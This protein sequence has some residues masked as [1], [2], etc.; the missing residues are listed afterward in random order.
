[1][2]K[3]SSIHPDVSIEHR[4]VTDRQTDRRTDTGP[5]LVPARVKTKLKRVGREERRSEECVPLKDEGTGVG[6]QWSANAESYRCTTPW[7]DSKLSST[8]PRAAADV[9][10]PDR[11]ASPSLFLTFTHTHTQTDTH[12]TYSHT[13]RVASTN[14]HSMHP[15]S[16]LNNKLSAN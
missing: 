1:M 6:E 14:I 10:S 9:A 13:R 11:G 2:L 5:W 7:T 4:L 3:T 16:T 12:Q 15:L 8:S